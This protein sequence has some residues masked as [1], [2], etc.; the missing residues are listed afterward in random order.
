MGKQDPVFQVSGTCELMLV[1][2]PNHRDV[3]KGR[4]A[5][6]DVPPAPP[7]PLQ[8]PPPPAEVTSRRFKKLA[9][10]PFPLNISLF[11]L[12][13]PNIFGKEFKNSCTSREHQKVTQAQGTSG[14]AS[15]GLGV[16]PSG[17]AP[18]RQPPLNSNNTEQ[19]TPGKGE[20]GISKDTSLDS[21]VQC[22]TK[23]KSQGYRETGKWG[24][25]KQTNKNELRKLSLRKF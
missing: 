23:K 7:H 2:A 10:F 12:S 22:P 16:Y 15:E 8:A 17:G 24:L 18:P 1:A 11:P 3:D 19:Q 13:E 21:N 6:V 20:R 25:L 5:I 14:K 4:A 9:P